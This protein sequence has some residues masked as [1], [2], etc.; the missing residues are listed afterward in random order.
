VDGPSLAVQIVRR[1]C[2]EAARRGVT[3][4]SLLID[5]TGTDEVLLPHHRHGGHPATGQP[6]ALSA[7]AVLAVTAGIVVVAGL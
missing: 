3:P 7:A 6:P 2:R 4:R 5:L 1:A